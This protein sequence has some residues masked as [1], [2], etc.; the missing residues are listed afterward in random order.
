[1]A[2]RPDLKTSPL[3]NHLVE[4][5]RSWRR[6][7]FLSRSHYYETLVAEGQHPREMIISCCDSRVHVT[8]IFQ[9]DSGE[10]FIHRNVA[11]LVPPCESSGE[12]HGTSAALEYAVRVLKVERLIVL[13]HSNCGGVAG[14]YDMCEG[15]APDLLESGSFIGRWIDILKP[16]YDRLPES[17]S[18]DER[19]SLFEKEGVVVSMENL[20]TFPWLASAVEAGSLQIIG[21]WTDIAAGKLEWWS[22][23][24][25]AFVPV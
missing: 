24:E 20:M 17:G 12:H 8:Q 23:R 3:P 4:R 25:K 6:H 21:L 15:G 13:G 1:M 5:Y 11:A 7:S 2:E 16:A 9:A 10:M 19:L 22:P 18:R 14:C